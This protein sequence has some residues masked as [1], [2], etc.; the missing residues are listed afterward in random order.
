MSI[1]NLRMVAGLTLDQLVERLNEA[2]G[3]SFSR[4]AMSAVE[5]GLRGASAELLA[6]LELAYGLEPGSIDVN[7]E[8]R[9]S[10]TRSELAS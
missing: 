2:A 6:A 7:Y 9:A 10:T 4:G 1:R 3:F 5:S 8:R